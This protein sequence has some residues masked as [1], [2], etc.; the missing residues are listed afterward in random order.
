[1]PKFRGAGA[2]TRETC[3]ASRRNEFKSERRVER[4]RGKIIPW[5]YWWRHALA[6][7][8]AHKRV[9]AEPVGKSYFRHENGRSVR[10]RGLL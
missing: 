7:P 8:A 9:E 10:V 2:C 6:D 5:S 4:A 1:M 3:R